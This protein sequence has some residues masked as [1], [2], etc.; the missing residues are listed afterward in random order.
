MSAAESARSVALLEVRLDGQ[1][2]RSP[3]CA[4]G[5][6]RYRP[7]ALNHFMLLNVLRRILATAH[8]CELLDYALLFILI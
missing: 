5:A 2:L 6:G 1:L 8:I 4:S 3:G 7:F